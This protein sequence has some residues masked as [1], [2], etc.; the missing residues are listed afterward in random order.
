[1][2][3]D[4]GKDRLYLLKHIMI[5]NVIKFIGESDLHDKQP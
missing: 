5:Y 2:Y 1:M 4:L 3:L